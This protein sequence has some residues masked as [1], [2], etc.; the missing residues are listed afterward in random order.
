MV[1]RAIPNSIREGYLAALHCLAAQDALYR[2][3]SMYTIY[4]YIDLYIYPQRGRLECNV[5]LVEQ[6]QESL[7]R[8]TFPKIGRID[9]IRK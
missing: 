4:K 7:A 2:L 9:K 1:T 5:S 3:F 6:C 8:F